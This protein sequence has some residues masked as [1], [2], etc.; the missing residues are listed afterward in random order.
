MPFNK[1]ACEYAYRMT[2]NKVLKHD[3]SNSGDKTKYCDYFAPRTMWEFVNLSEG[4]PDYCANVCEGI[5]FKID[6]E[7]FGLDIFS[8]L[9]FSRNGNF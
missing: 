1:F 4:Y 5:R 8:F 6:V 3:F 9:R 2:K 7:V